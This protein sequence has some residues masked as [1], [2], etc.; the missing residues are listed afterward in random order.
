MVFIG[1]VKEIFTFPA[2]N[3]TKR[4]GFQKSVKC[5]HIITDQTWLI[6]QVKGI[7]GPQFLGTEK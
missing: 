6:K 7:P 1:I 5:G 4:P 2:F 3:E